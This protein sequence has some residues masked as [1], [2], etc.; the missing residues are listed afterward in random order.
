M[1]KRYAIEGEIDVSAKG[2]AETRSAV[3]DLNAELGRLDAAQ[4]KVRGGSGTSSSTAA[5]RAAADALRKQAAELERI[6]QARAREIEAQREETAQLGILARAIGRGSA[7]EREAN[8][9]LQIRQSLLRGNIQAGSAEAAVVEQQIRQQVRY[10]EQL[11]QAASAK[12]R[13]TRGALSFRNALLALQGVIAA[14]GL[15]ALVRSAV[16]LVTQFEGISR[17]LTIVFGSGNRAREG[18]ADLRAESD[19]MGVSF[20]ETAQSYARFLAAARGSLSVEQTREVFLSVTQA[21]AQMGVSSEQTERALL[22][23]QQMA[24]KG[25]VSAEELRQQLGEALPGALQLA[26]RALGKTIPEF[27]KLLNNGQILSKDLLPKLAVE[28]RNAFGVDLNK[29]VETTQATIN[30]LRNDLEQLRLVFG[31]G[32]LGGFSSGFGGLSRSLS[33]QDT[34]VQARELGRILG[35]A[36]RLASE[37]VTALVRQLSVLKG[38]LAGVITLRTG[39]YFI[40][41]AKAIRDAGGAAAYFGQS[42][43]LASL[44]LGPLAIAVAAVTWAISAYLTQRERM[45]IED[46]RRKAQAQDL[47]TYLQELRRRTED[48]TQAE[49]DLLKTRQA[50]LQA[51]R[52]QAVRDLA[53]ARRIASAKV[54]ESSQEAFDNAV[55]SDPQ[56]KAARQRVDELTGMIKEIIAVNNELASKPKPGDILDPASLDKTTQKI[57]DLVRKYQDAAIK[58]KE[59]LAIQGQEASQIPELTRRI[60]AHYEARAAVAELDGV[61]AKTKAALAAQIEKL[62]LAEKGT[63]LEIERSV[64]ARQRQIEADVERR[65]S[66]AAVADALAGADAASRALEAQIRA[67]TIARQDQREGD[68]LYIQILAGQILAQDEALR[69]DQRRIAAQERQIKAAQDL[70]TA[71]AAYTDSLTGLTA[72][73]KATALAIEIENALRGETLALGS[74]EAAKREKEIRD[75]HDLKDA[76]DA[77][78]SSRLAWTAALKEAGRYEA[79]TQ[80]WIQQAE[81]ASR[82]GQE[83][84]SILA[85]NNLL[86]DATRRL[87]QQEEV[88]NRV[89]KESLDIKDPENRD[90]LRQI[91]EEVAQEDELLRGVQQ[92]RAELQLAAYAAQPLAEAWRETTRQITDFATDAIANWI[93][94]IET[95]WKDLLKNLVSM[96][97][98]ALVEMAARKLLVSLVADNTSLIGGGKIAA[99]ELA[100]GGK[101]AASALVA[102]AQ[103]AAAQLATGGAAGGAGGATGGVLTGTVVGKNFLGLSSSSWIAIAGAAAVVAFAVWNKHRMDHARDSSYDTQAQLYIGSNSRIAGAGGKLTERAGEILAAMQSVVDALEGSTGVFIESMGAVAVQVRHDKKAFRAM[104]DGELIGVFKTQEEAIVA[105]MRASILRADI[106]GQLDPAVRQ[107]LEKGQF[108][109]ADQ[110]AGAIRSVQALVDSAAGL[111]DL[112]TQMRASQQAIRAWVRTLT[113]A[114]VDIA[115]AQRIAAENGRRMLQGWRDQITGRQQT[116]QEQAAQQQREA[117]LYNA[118]LALEAA[119]LDAEIQLTEKRIAAMEAGVGAQAAQLR[120]EEEF[121]NARGQILEAEG[122]MMGSYVSTVGN[123]AGLSQEQLQ[124]LL[125]ALR[126]ARAALPEAIDLGSLRPVGS[127]GG[128]GRQQAR[129]AF[130]DELRQI[131]GSGASEALQRIRDLARQIQDL[132]DRARETGASTDLLNQAIAE[133]R[134]QE[135]QRYQDIVDQ[136]LGGS[137]LTGFA[138]QL[139]AIRQKYEDLRAA[140]EESLATTGALI[141]ARWKLNAAEAA[142]MAALGQQVLARLNAIAGQDQLLGQIAEAVELLRLASANLKELGLSE[143]DLE[144]AR[145]RAGQALLLSVAENMARAAGNEAELKR[146]AQLRW[147]FEK[148]NMLLQIKALEAQAKILGI[149]EEQIQHLYDLYNGLPA[150]PPVTGGGGGGG[151]GDTTQ[152]GASAIDEALRLLQQYEQASALDGLSDGQRRLR[153]IESD[154]DTIFR[155]MGRN[156]RTLKAY[157]EAIEALNNSLIDPLRQLQQDLLGGALSG[158]SLLGQIDALRSQAQSLFALT[159]TGTAE[160]RVQALEQ[161]PQVLQQLLQA[162]Q[163]GYGGGAG[164]LAIRQFVLAILSR[165]TGLPAGIGGGTAGGGGSA[166]G[167]GRPNLGNVVL[168]GDAFLPDLGTSAS[169]RTATT[170]DDLGRRFDR[171]GGAIDRLTMAVLQNTARDAT[172]EVAD[173]TAEVAEQLRKLS[174][175]PLGAQRLKRSARR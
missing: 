95:N 108:E 136:A 153:Q 174:R 162:A 101:L 157:R 97:I 65:R 140:N 54:F 77:A 105:A 48:L 16:E 23:L 148:A 151:A 91:Q 68:V 143:A 35:E 119:R 74:P 122:R 79:E 13:A 19:R 38:I 89:R 170:S 1:A 82:Y 145:Q 25:T 128:G 5:D 15:S 43:R 50:S 160:Q 146:I 18:L 154:F 156:E 67:E 58:A 84:T 172:G 70:R 32:F 169:Q 124:R 62:I 39:A 37:A 56:V 17:T 134:R 83:I 158:S 45:R 102:G 159:Q 109:N 150:A 107:V 22:A 33:S 12:E 103:A 10:K 110:L 106:A 36:M 44:Q 46:E 11:S 137:S 121:V 42:I 64:A 72:A 31:Q 135:H 115:D 24:S 57:A 164:Y 26:A 99:T 28:I 171:L 55:A 161:L 73:T 71:E 66:S 149:S 113:D 131:I 117:A 118:Q 86:S 168:A 116:A 34:L 14:L 127:G 63:T 87:A 126:A 20:R 41:L 49:R 132:R 80:D 51:E 76:L 75:Q 125:D 173:N 94:G 69:A 141:I 142:E 7:A 104:L 21:L 47:S 90:R 147:D 53:E 165:I 8:I 166:D 93:L 30:R 100:T 59:L 29:R 78:T 4:K 88:L 9:Q 129:Q 163:Q 40:G 27:N 133:L 144:A 2:V 98:K 112:E 123:L 52:A 138:E 167:T 152:A 114:G 85:Q 3:R 92:Y 120:A 155:A 130:E 60:E 96:W 139:G 111:S 6:A 81:A 61:D 175:D